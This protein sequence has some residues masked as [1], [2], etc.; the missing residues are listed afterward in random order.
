MV[1]NRVGTL[2]SCVAMLLSAPVYADSVTYDYVGKDFT[3]FNVG[4]TQFTT[5][6]SVTGFITLS[7]PLP[8]TI[9]TPTTPDFQAAFPTTFSFSNGVSNITNANAV[10]TEF[11]F[12]TDSVGKIIEWQ[13]VVSNA[14]GLH[15]ST[16]DFPGGAGVLDSTTTL[17][18][19]D[20]GTNINLPG[21]WSIAAVP[22][23]QSYA[24]MLSGLGLLAFITRRRR[25]DQS[26]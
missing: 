12:E 1:R 21:T 15:I 10:S 3:S 23:P 18:D 22:E 25:G 19:S 5:S 11:E 6:D 20:S 16:I 17:N 13:V 24:L 2:A 7:A 14:A 26:I 9:P 4:A 8:A